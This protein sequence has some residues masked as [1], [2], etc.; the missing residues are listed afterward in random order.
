MATVVYIY[1]YATRDFIDIYF[2]C[3]YIYLFCIRGSGGY[4]VL[5]GYVQSSC[6]AQ[7]R[8]WLPAH[9]LLQSLPSR[10]S[11]KPSFASWVE[12]R[13][14]VV[15]CVVCGSAHVK[16]IIKRK[17]AQPNR[18]WN[19]RYAARSPN[20]NTLTSFGSRSTASEGWKCC[21]NVFDVLYFVILYVLWRQRCGTAHCELE[22]V[23]G[24]DRQEI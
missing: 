20:K 4:L 7:Q 23:T 5:E 10:I 21:D 24:L 2:I 12:N 16:E 19:E 18:H 17:C 8:G 9:S 13:A 3:I 15:S 14:I 1:A 22:R 6:T 11:Y